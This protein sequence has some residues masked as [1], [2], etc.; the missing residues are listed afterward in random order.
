M[1]RMLREGVR[2]QGIGQVQQQGL[3]GCANLSSYCEMNSE[4][5][6][7]SITY[8]LV[9]LRFAALGPA[10]LRGGSILSRLGQTGQGRFT[11][12]THVV[13]A[14]DEAL[15]QFIDSGGQPARLAR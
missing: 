4:N 9:Q 7:I 13:A 3:D 11:P 2:M 1:P 10:W 5:A 8:E 15:A 14:R 6:M 12:P